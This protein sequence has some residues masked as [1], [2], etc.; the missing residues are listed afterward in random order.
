MPCDGV[1]PSA[2]CVSILN[3]AVKAGFNTDLFATRRRIAAP[4]VPMQVALPQ[5][6]A[7]LP[8]RWFWAGAHRRIE[9]RFLASI[10]PGEIAYL[11]P[12][13]SLEA[14]RILHDR[15]IPIV[16]EGINTRMA[17]AKRILDEAYTSLGAPPSHGITEARIA[18]EEEKFCC[19]SAIFAPNRNVELA[20]LDSP[21]EHCIIPS[22]YG[23]DTSRALPPRGDRTTDSGALTFLFCGYVCVRKGAHLLLDAWRR[24]PGRHRLQLVGRIEP[25]IAERFRD[26]LASDRVDVVGFVK[27]VHPYFAAADVFVFPSLEEGD[28]LVTYEAAL[29]GLPIIASAMGASRLGDAGDTVSMVHPLN[30]DRLLETMTG[31][32]EDPLARLTFG[33]RARAEVDRFDW[34]RVGADR[35]ERLHGLRLADGVARAK[36]VA[37]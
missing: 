11:W 29:H 33:H 5:A 17:S 35:F 32:A 25:L 1:G 19:A 18:E 34:N 9:V 4:A 2:T 31:V 22:S 13:A 24:M 20:L 27:D 26:V 8:T 30:V 7:H 28:P 12:A 37:S 10:R 6:L 15:G 16:L 3:G 21:L 23:V 36:V 14:H